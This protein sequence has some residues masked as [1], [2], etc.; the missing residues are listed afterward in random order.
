MRA[1]AR[2]SEIGHTLIL[3]SI[4]GVEA[5]W[6]APQVEQH[7]Y[8]LW[9]LLHQAGA[10]GLEAMWDY[11]EGNSAAIMAAAVEG[12]ELIGDVELHHAAAEYWYQIASK[13]GVSKVAAF[14]TGSRSD[15]DVTENAVWCA[16]PGV[17]E[18]KELKDLSNS[19]VSCW[20]TAF[21]ERV[22][23]WLRNYEEDLRP[24]LC[25]NESVA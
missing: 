7:L 23:V 17:F 14:S 20:D 10:N 8:A 16:H 15:Y 13:A 1:D 19:F 9:C 18:G 5:F 3:T 6:C 12:L 21:P 25:E 2:L 11:N 4:T 22:L 24:H